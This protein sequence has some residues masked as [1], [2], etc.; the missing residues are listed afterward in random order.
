M[1]DKFED[2]IRESLNSPP[3]Y[4]FEERVWQ[5]LEGRLDQLDKRQPRTGFPFWWLPVLAAAV[6]VLLLF[7][8][9]GAYQ[10]QGAELAQLQQLPPQGQVTI[11]DT[12]VRRTV[13]VEYDTVYHTVYETT[14]IETDPKFRQ[15]PFYPTSL[16]PGGERLSPTG[17]YE[18][19]WLPWQSGPSAQGTWPRWSETGTTGEDENLLNT[20]DLAV[21]ETAIRKWDQ[22]PTRPLPFRFFFL[23]YAGEEALPAIVIPTIEQRKKTLADRV[24]PILPSEVR[25]GFSA[26]SFFAN[27]L[28]EVEKQSN[29]S[30]A[31]SAELSYSRHLSVVFGAEY[32]ANNFGLKHDDDVDFNGFPLV[33]PN[34]PGD[35]LERLQGDFRYWQFPLG[36]KYRMLVK[37]RL[38][39]YLGGGIM[40]IRPT[41]SLLNYEYENSSNDYYSLSQDNLLGRQLM[42]E[43]VW[44]MLGAEYYLGKN[45]SVLL[46]ANAQWSFGKANNNIEKR[47]YFKLRLGFGYAF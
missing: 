41:Q 31:L 43:D 7:W 4:P 24:A 14:K 2:K 17:S 38:S 15:R 29:F 26:G 12:I 46:D 6:P 3:D 21:R 33:P 5:D 20:V 47:E 11:M 44:L 45:W 19:K 40:A 1:D 22:V 32:L 16:L 30:G 25:I 37:K 39:P 10:Q 13:I 8:L 36:I 27:G 18:N 35:E 28:P 23:N 9:W 42:L 34:T